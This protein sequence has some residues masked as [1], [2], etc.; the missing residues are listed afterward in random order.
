[1]NDWE[2]AAPIPN[3]EPAPHVET[4]TEKRNR[5]RAVY[6]VVLVFILMMAMFGLNAWYTNHVDEKNRRDWCDIIVAITNNNRANPTAPAGSAQERFA[7]LME[8][9]R[10][11]L[12]CDRG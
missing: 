9:R 2:E 11:T 10:R 6:S 5:L 3:G 8:G 4:A 12:G 1:M 7:R